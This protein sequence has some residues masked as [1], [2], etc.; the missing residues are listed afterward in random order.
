MRPKER[1]DDFLAKVNW[2][3]LQKKW[4]IPVL[5]IDTEFIRKSWKENPDQR[6]GQLLINLGLIED[7]LE[8]WVTEE[9]TILIDQGLPPEECLY[10]T[11]MYDEN[12]V[13]LE[14]PKTRLVATLTPEHINNIITFMY[15][16]GGRISPDMQKAFD[17]VLLS[18]SPPEEELLMA[19]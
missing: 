14:T 12:E 3:E 9:A 13:L 18:K 19:A 4:K 15:N 2:S 16:Y 10:W 5:E 1:I 17:N 11:S 7:S 6:I 8:K